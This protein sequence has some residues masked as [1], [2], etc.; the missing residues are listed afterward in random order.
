MVMGDGTV[1]P[2]MLYYLK[3]SKP[4]LHLDLIRSY[5]SEAEN[6]VLLLRSDII[7]VLKDAKRETVFSSFLGGV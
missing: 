5:Y 1:M 4:R 6:W 2:R 3:T 7:K